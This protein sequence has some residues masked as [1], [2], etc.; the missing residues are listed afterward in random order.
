M[1]ATASSSRPSAG[2]TLADDVRIRLTEEIVTGAHPPG[3]KLD[4]V[5]LAARFEV[6]RTPVREA[7]RQLVNSGLVVWRPRQGAVVA[8]VSVP[9]MIEMFEMMAELEGFAGRLAARRMTDEQRAQLKQLLDKGRPHAPQ[10]DRQAY[11][12]HNR[13]FHLAI[14]RGAHNHYLQDQASTLYDR[15]AP[16]R[17]YELN[18]PGE[19]QRVYREHEAIVQAIL[20]RDSERVYH[21]LKEHAMLDIDLLGDL[22]ATLGR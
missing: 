13:A 22:T 4:E 15:L 19:I 21:L 6:S 9:Q 11:Q 18:R 16:Y 17:A 8:K 3:T 7:L 10:P 12:R 14:Y 20:S 5:S 1:N 2:T